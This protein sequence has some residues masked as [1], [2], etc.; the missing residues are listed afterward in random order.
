[1][2]CRFLAWVSVKFGCPSKHSKNTSKQK[3][4]SRR[5]PLGLYDANF[6]G[7]ERTRPDRS[8]HFSDLFAKCAFVVHFALISR[9]P[10]L[11]SGRILSPIWPEP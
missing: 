3:N 11:I 2:A 9:F 4:A 5:L 10:L 6:T 7:Q 1:M 8:G